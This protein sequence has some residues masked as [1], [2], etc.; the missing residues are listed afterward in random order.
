MLLCTIWQD[1]KL[2]LESVSEQVYERAVR[3]CPWC[4]QLWQNYILLLER[5]GKPYERVKGRGFAQKPC[6]KTIVVAEFWI[7]SLKMDP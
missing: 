5:M 1:H 6:Y 2:K 3:N 4:V 7:N